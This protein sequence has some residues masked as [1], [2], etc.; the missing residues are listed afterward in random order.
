MLCWV[1]RVQA[2]LRPTDV[3]AL[4][5]ALYSLAPDAVGDPAPL[6]SLTGREDAAYAL[7]CGEPSAGEYR[8]VT[9]CQLMLSLN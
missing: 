2:L 6:P 9:H 8:I 1:L 3:M 7:I 4:L 5:P